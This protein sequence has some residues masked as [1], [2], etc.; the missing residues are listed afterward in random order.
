MTNTCLNCIYFT[1]KTKNGGFCNNNPKGVKNTK[2]DGDVFVKPR[3]LS[4]YYCNNHVEK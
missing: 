3:V 1:R 2:T 4:Y